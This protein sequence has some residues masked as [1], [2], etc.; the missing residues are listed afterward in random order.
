MALLNIMIEAYS[1]GIPDPFRHISRYCT[2]SPAPSSTSA[3]RTTCPCRSWPAMRA[4]RTITGG[5]DFHQSPP[6]PGFS[7]LPVSPFYEAKCPS[8]PI[9]VRLHIFMDTCHDLFGRFPC[10]SFCVGISI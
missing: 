1:D 6:H 4:A 8:R 9:V 10:G 7:I 2:S 3:S 5:L